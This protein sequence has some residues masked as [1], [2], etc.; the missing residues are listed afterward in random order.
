VDSSGFSA[1]LDEILP[2]LTLYKQQLRQLAI[3]S[4]K[5]SDNAAAA[6]AAIET[7]L[8]NAGIRSPNDQD[9]ERRPFGLV[10]LE[11]VQ[12]ALQTDL[13]SVLFHLHLAHG[14]DTSLS[15]FRHGS[16]N[17]D[18]VF[19]LDRNE[20]DTDFY[21]MA[22]PQFTA[23]DANGS[24]LM[25]LASDSERY[26]D[27]GYRL[28]VDLYRID[29]AFNTKDQLSHQTFDGKDHQ[30]ALDAN[31]FRL[32]TISMEHDAARAGYRVF[33]YRY[34]LHSD[35]LI[36][37]API[38]FDA[39][40]FVGE[41]GNL[42]W[43]EAAK[44]SDPANITRIREYYNKLRTTEG[45]FGGEFGAVQT[46]DPQQKTWQVEYEGR[47]NA[48]LYFQVER[49]DKWT[50]IVKDI[51]EKKQDGC[52]DVEW[53]SGQPFLTMFSKPLEW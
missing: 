15:I 52:K 53:R 35:Q 9:E 42:P 34:E 41:W 10:N 5:D 3:E 50:F 29:G 48:S 1:A 37:V 14:T 30:I 45:Y 7:K 25:L 22:P 47:D 39:Y 21:H 46:C 27:G 24:F 32:E 6:K 43:D 40:D 49:K 4:L 16:A 51:S 36:R 31:G 17:W 13:L 38:G 20:R 11:I 8:R 12:P 19:K 26:G 2:I 23:S 33:P 44:W 28:L 18:L